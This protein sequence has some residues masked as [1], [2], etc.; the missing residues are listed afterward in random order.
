MEKIRVAVLC[1]SEIAFRRFMPA[2]KKI[3]NATFVG[4]AHANEEEW[5]GNISKDHN[6]DVLNIDSCKAKNFIDNY[7]GKIFNSFSD[8]ITSKDVDAIYIPLPPA[9]HFKWA[10]KALENG[11]HVLVE[12]PSTTSLRDTNEL[13][14]LASKN[15]LALH[16]NYMFNFHSQIDFIENKIKE[17]VIGDVRLYRISFGFPFRGNNDFRYNKKLGGGA[18]LDCGGY[19]IK[20]ATRLL[21]NNVKLLAHQ[22]NYIKNYD[23]DMYGSGTLVN[24]NNEVAQISFGM[25]NSYKCDLEAWGSKGII[26]TNRILTAPVGYSPV[27]KITSNNET[28]DIQLEPDDSFKKSIEHFLFCINNKTSRLENYEQILIQEK[29]IDI[30]KGG[31]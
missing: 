11:K 9:L 24:N 26:S 2:L 15:N 7:G 18:L 14:N 22:L 3:K 30:F 4:I 20:L 10:K 29:F 16:E 12:K 23:V 21:G 28:I 19:T 6:L 25:D 31:N 5:F 1:P 8:L 27:V 17:G 13:I